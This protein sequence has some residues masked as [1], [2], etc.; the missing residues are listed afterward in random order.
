VIDG[1][2]H[3]ATPGLAMDLFSDLLPILNHSKPLVRKKAVLVMYKIFLQYP[4]ALRVAF[5]R[6]R[7]KLD[8]A[9]ICIPPSYDKTDR[10]AVVSATVNVICELARKNPKN[11]L[12][13]APQL[14]N[15]LTTSDN[16]WMVIK[17]IKLVHSFS[18]ISNM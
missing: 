4:D 8:D 18:R 9:D 13:L 17:V 16:N 14:F 3:I 10:A 7:E 6:L 15:L 5:P 12:P 1:L 2:A 11:Y